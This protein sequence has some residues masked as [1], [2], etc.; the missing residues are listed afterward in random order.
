M[1]EHLVTMWLLMKPSCFPNPN[2]GLLWDVTADIELE[3]SDN[4][5]LQDLAVIHH[6]LNLEVEKHGK[7]LPTEPLQGKLLSDWME[8][9][10]CVR[11]RSLL[12]NSARTILT[13]SEA[14]RK[15]KHVG[16][17]RDGVT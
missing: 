5:S 17:K 2:A 12:V 10:T 15:I 6:L 11:N 9:T 1:G 3:E 14:I 13:V 8:K 7:K 16:R 4:G